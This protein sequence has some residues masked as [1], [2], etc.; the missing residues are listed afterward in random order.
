MKHY[1]TVFKYR[2]FHDFSNLATGGQLNQPCQ[3]LAETATVV[4]LTEPRGHLDYFVCK[5]LCISWPPEHERVECIC[6]RNLSGKE[7]RFTSEKKMFEWNW[8][9][10][11]N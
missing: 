6:G 9:E 10:K 4:G 8:K 1:Y 3:L 7:Q 5:F 11:R 2:L